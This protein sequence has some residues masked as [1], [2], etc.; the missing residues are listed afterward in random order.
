MSRGTAVLLSLIMAVFLASYLLIS[1]PREKQIRIG[2]ILGGVSTLDVM[3]GEGPLG[4]SQ[5][6][7]REIQF[8]KTLDLA[9]A[10]STGEV[11]VAVIPIE[12]AAKLRQGGADVLVVAVDMF[13]NQAVLVGRESDIRSPGDLAGRVVGVFTPTGTYAMF[14]AYMREIYGIDP[15]E[16]MILVDEPPP[17]LIQAFSDGELDAVVLWEPLVSKALASGGRMLVNFSD[18]WSEWAGG[19]RPVMI[20]YAANGNFVR[21]HPDLL[22]ELV[23]LR[24]EAARFW[25]SHRESILDMLEENYGL[26][27][28]AAES[29]YDRVSIWEGP[30][31]D[32][33]VRAS[34]KVLRLAWLGGYLREDP[35][36]LG[37][38]FFWRG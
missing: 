9:R 8:E 28:P 11:D 6:E 18:L 14:R 27:R 36:G 15:E 32:D 16:D 34:M 1:P 26:T 21:S 4:D 23:G 2:T 33:V 3:A 12:M 20:V 13:Q 17:S 31:T 7:V 22:D 25:N 29:A 37:E 10:L 5:V 19:G 38:T 30:L 35:E 24:M